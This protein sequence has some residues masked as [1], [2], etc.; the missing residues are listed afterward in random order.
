MSDFELFHFLTMQGEGGWT[1]F[2]KVDIFFEKKIDSPWKENEKE[3][4]NVF[5]ILDDPLEILTWKA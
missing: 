5:F 3:S 4:E 2:F 1:N